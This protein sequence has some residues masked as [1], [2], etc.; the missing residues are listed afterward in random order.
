MPKHPTLG[1]LPR[2][3]TQKLVAQ[4]PFDLETPVHNLSGGQR[5]LLA[6]AMALQQNPSVL[7]L[8]KPTAAIDTE[9]C[10]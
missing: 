6:I 9:K 4:L 1:S 7:L 10:T 5:Q 8:D 2:I 3:D